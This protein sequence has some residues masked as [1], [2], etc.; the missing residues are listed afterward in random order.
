MAAPSDTDIP[1]IAII[2]DDIGYHRHNGMRAATFPANLTLAI[3]PHSP[4][5]PAL[6]LA[7]HKTGKEII[8]H[9]PMSNNRNLPLDPGAL[10]EKMAYKDFLTTL[11]KDLEAI[12]HIKGVSNHMGSRLTQQYRPMEWL[13]STLKQRGL[14]FVDSRTSADSLAWEVALAHKLPSL[15]RDIFLDNSR[16]SEDIA[17]QFQNLIDI[18]RAKGFAVAIGHP[19]TQTLDSLKRLLMTVDK[20]KVKLVTISQLLEQVNVGKIKKISFIN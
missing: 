16:R 13:M 11:G 20:N 19:Y 12:P 4:N 7:G 18:A 17:K 6:A 2:I 1:R 3:I 8:L 15:K 10:T 9:I 5:G 14:Y